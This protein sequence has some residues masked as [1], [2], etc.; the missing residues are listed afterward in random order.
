MIVGTDRG[1][2]AGGNSKSRR[3]STLDLFGVAQ[4]ER[5]VFLFGERWLLMYCSR[6]DSV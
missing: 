6:F 4:F 3:L 2:G 5:V 1:V